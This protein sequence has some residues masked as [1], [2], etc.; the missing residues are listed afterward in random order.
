MTLTLVSEMIRIA[1]SAIWANKLRSFLTILGNIVAISSIITLVSLIQGITEEVTDV[2]LTEV[3]ADAFMVDRRGIIRSQEQF[4]RARNNPLITMDDA[5]A[6]R[7]FAENVTAVMVQ[8]QRSGEV[9]YRHRL[10]E[11]VSIQGVTEDFT[12]FSTFNA[13]EGRLMTPSEVQRRR[14]VTVLGAETAERLFETL[15]PIDRE[16]RIQGVPFRVVGVSR[17][18]GS[19]FGVSQDEYA[20]IPLGAFR[21]LFGTRSSLGIRV[22]PADPNRI[23]TAIGETTVALRIERRLRPDEEDNFGIF[24][25]ET[26]LGLFQQATTGIFSVLVGVVGLA[27]V[28]A[29]IVIMNIML[30]AVSERTKEIGLRKAL[31][32]RRRDIMWQMLSESVVLA[33]AG[34]I[35]GTALGAVAAVAIDRFA[36]VPATVHLWSVL[37]AITLTGLVGLFFGMYPAA[38]AAALDPIDALGRSD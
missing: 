38:R 30:M 22:Q 36:P 23:D 14:N 16:V 37:L 15:D 13:E 1:L 34:G 18:V 5:D 17:P 9:R 24:T 2:I 27:M 6:I 21:R 25:S 10:L 19:T 20:I 4:E 28:V 35:A 12:S 32:A 31:G 11:Q 3:G 29:G 33:L 7:R 8:A 26:A